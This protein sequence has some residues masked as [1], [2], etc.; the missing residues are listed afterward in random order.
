MSNSDS[1]PFVHSDRIQFE[2]WVWL[3]CAMEATSRK[4]GNVHPEASFGDLTYA[5]FIKSADAI[6]PVVASAHEVGVG[7]TILDAV[8]KTRAAVGQNTNLGIVL[9]LTPLAAV[10]SA[11]SARTI[12]PCWAAWR[13]RIRAQRRDSRSPISNV[14]AAIRMCNRTLVAL[15]GSRGRTAR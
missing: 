6:A 3:A 8:I 7:R 10:P 2:N 14:V 9:L 12:S 15:S 5:D 11:I 1:S 13:K 4:P